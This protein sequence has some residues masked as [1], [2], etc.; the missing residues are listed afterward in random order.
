VKGEMVYMDYPSISKV[1]NLENG[2]LIGVDQTNNNADK[3]CLCIAKLNDGVMDIKEI[4]YIE[5]QEDMDKYINKN[6]AKI[7]GALGISKFD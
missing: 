6:T 5:K 1:Y 3:T 7:Y 2:V 4:R